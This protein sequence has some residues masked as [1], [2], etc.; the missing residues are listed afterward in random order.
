M[1]KRA[2][3]AGWI[4]LILASMAWAHGDEQHVMGIVTKI[5]GNV[6]SVRTTDGAVKTVMVTATTRFV[7]NGS[8]LTLK[9]LKV[10]DRVV[11]HAKV[12]GNL[13]HAMEVKIGEATKPGRLP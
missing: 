3:V 2:L 1:M 7:K 8:A 11:M 5:D 13:L 4:V 9:D 10:D 12:M 6:I